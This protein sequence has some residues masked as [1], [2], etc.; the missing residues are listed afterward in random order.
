MLGESSNR[1][2]KLNI[3]GSQY[4]LRE[5]LDGS[6]TMLVKEAYLSDLLAHHEVPAPR[7]LATVAAEHIGTLTTFAEGITLG[8]A[9]E[10]LSPDDLAAAWRS[11]GEALRRAHEIEQPVAGEIVGDRIEPF[12][13]GWAT[14]A[15]EDVTDTLGWLR[16]QAG[17]P[18]LGEDAERFSQS[19]HSVLADAPI[20]LI[21]NDL[22]PQN[23]MVAPGPDGWR[24]TA[25]LDWE[26]ARAGDPR[27]DLA[28][29]DLR[30]AELVPPAFYE[31]YG[32]RPAEPHA[33]IYEVLAMAW[34]TK[35]QL[36][37]LGDWWWTPLN[38]R[39]AYVAN[40]ERHLARAVPPLPT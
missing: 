25:L 15:G 22:L 6:P 5:R 8:R 1:V 27:W 33:T 3:G 37:G 35:A 34:K 7:V 32:E 29:L 9:L 28:T 13:G 20:R 38:A 17:M 19:M 16:E 36:Q 10:V 26:L 39:L 31:G 11:T 2:W 23:I 12:A 21:H 40:L 4:V 14:W 24:C 30:P 18:A